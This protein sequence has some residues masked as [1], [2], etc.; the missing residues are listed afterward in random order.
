LQRGGVSSNVANVAKAVNAAVARLLRKARRLR[1][2]RNAGPLDP[3]PSRWLAVLG[4]AANIVSLDAVAATRL[5]VIV[6]DLAA[7]DRAKLDALDVAWCRRIR[8]TSS[9]ATLRRVTRRNW[10]FN[11]HD[12]LNRRHRRNKTGRLPACRFFYASPRRR[13]LMR[14]VAV[15][16]HLLLL[17][18]PHHVDDAEGERHADAENPG[19]TMMF[20]PADV[21]YVA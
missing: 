18:E 19:S 14:V 16:L 10:R 9:S 11:R 3:N 7:V 21:A 15:G 20:A 17:V 1:R 2:A 12:R 13:T 5:R 8:C 6:R 4:G